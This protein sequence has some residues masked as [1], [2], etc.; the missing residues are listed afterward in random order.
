MLTLKG[1]LLNFLAVSSGIPTS[2]SKA[3]KKGKS[4][5]DVFQ[6]PG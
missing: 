3:S 5:T 2:A 4:K 6:H 1:T